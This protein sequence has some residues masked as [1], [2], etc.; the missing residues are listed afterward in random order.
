MTM[1]RSDSETM[2]PQVSW[3]LYGKDCIFFQLMSSVIV[4]HKSFWVTKQKNFVTGYSNSPTLTWCPW[5]GIVAAS[6]AL[7]KES[8]TGA[9]CCFG[10]EI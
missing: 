10:G 2:M 3:C 6:S 1:T 5:G 4:A 8:F 7:L 9:S